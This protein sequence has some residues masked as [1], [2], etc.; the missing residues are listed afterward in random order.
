MIESLIFEY[1]D[2]IDS[3]EGP[4][5]E[6][7][8]IAGDDLDGS[9]LGLPHK[10][11][12]STTKAS[13]I[14]HRSRGSQFG[15][16]LVDEAVE[17]FDLVLD[18]HHLASPDGL[19]VVRIESDMKHRF[20]DLEDD[21]VAE[22]ADRL[23]LLAIRGGHGGGGPNAQRIATRL[24]VSGQVEAD[25]T[26]VLCRRDGGRAVGDPRRQSG[27]DQLH[28]G[29]MIGV[30]ALDLDRDIEHA[31]GRVPHVE[32]SE[33]LV[34]SGF[35]A[36]GRDAKWRVAGDTDGQFL[37]QAAPTVGPSRADDRG[38]SDGAFEV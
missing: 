16:D 21:G 15:V 34:D 24:Q 32:F 36:V 18:L 5:P 8:V 31:S 33:E 35:V 38:A 2:C 9:A 14:G 6:W 23:S 17:S 20:V 30:T 37:G 22:D 3:Q 19:R 10:G 1:T 11:H 28:V 25:V 26:L 29:P 12:S 7:C 13:D 27:A 4:L